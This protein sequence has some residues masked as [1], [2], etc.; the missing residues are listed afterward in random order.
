MENSLSLVIGLVFDISKR[1][2]SRNKN[3]LNY[4]TKAALQIVDLLLWQRLGAKEA[5]SH[6]SDSLER[7]L[8]QVFC[9]TFRPVSM[10]PRTDVASTDFL[11]D[12]NF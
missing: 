4:R 10:K 8:I 12:V 7:S 5:L 3:Y 6:V 1:Y 9:R 2:V 11:S